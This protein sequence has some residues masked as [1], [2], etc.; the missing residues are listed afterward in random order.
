MFRALLA[1]AVGRRDE[2]IGQEARLCRGNV[3]EP[4][5]HDVGLFLSSLIFRGMRDVGWEMWQVSRANYIDVKTCV[6]SL[7]G[8]GS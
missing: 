7:P 4:A 1:D 2:D 5:T 6:L 8:D 3:G